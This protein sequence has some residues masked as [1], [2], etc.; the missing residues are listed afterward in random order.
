MTKAI[1][2]TLIGRLIHEGWFD[3]VYDPAPA[4]LWRDPR[5]IHRLITL[6]HLVRMRSGLGF[7]VRTT[8]AASRSGSRTARSTR[9]P[10]MRSRRRNARSSRRC[11]G[12]V[13]R[14]VNSGMNVLGAVIRDQIERRGLPYHPDGLSTAGRSA[15]HAQLPAFGR[16]RRQPDRLRRRFRHLARLRQARRAVP[17]G[18]RVERRAV[19]AAKA[20]S[21]TRLTATHTGTSYAACFR[22]NID[23]PFPDRAAGYRLGVRCVR[24]AHLH[25]APPSVDRRGDRTRPII[26]WTSPRSTG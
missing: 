20:G 21:I 18:R 14:Y 5:A 19:A 12:R 16:H 13:F 7:P 26:R 25:P 6:D 15:R 8:T 24:P 22:T 11:P 4:P 23:R 17:E 3:S 2:C 10:A 1:T 9:T